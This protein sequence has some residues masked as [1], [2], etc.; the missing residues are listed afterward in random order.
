MAAIV[1]E[2]EQGVLVMTLNRPERLN[3]LDP[4]MATA[5]HAAFNDAAADSTVRCIVVRGAGDGFMAG[6]DLRFF[7]QSLQKLS[8]GDHRPLKAIFDDVH[9]AIRVMYALPKPIIAC[10]HGA[11]AGFGVSLM[12]ACDLVIAAEDA[13]FTLAY[14]HIGASPDGGSTFALPRVIGLKRS[15]ELGL[16]GERFDADRALSLGLVN[17]VVPAEQLH[18]RTRDLAA[19]LACGPTRAYANTKMLLNASLDADLNQQLD[20]EQNAFL[21]CAGS[22]DF[23]EGVDAFLN[24]RRPR[25][26][27]R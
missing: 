11:V 13:V 14:C 23:A 5:L 1:T 21:D 22:E 26:R 3:V 16:L 8:H 6:G 19:R 9:G 27:G 17:W 10:V 20:R 24:K 25:F 12:T 18:A 4:H 7:E 2:K 15:M